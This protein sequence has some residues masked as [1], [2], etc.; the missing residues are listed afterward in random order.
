MKQGYKQLRMTGNEPTIGKDHLFGILREVDKT[1]LLFILET[2]GILI[3]HDRHYSEQL[4]AFARAKN[5][6]LTSVTHTCGVLFG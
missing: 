5:F 1:S 2:N 3:G 4:S 6:K